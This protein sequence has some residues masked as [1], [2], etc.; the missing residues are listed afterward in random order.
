MPLPLSEFERELRLLEAELKRLEAEYNQF[1]A[2]RLP[3][4]PWISVR[5]WTR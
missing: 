2:G 3:R 4:L 1:F 5:A